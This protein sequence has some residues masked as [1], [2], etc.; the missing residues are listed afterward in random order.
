MRTQTT[1]KLLLAFALSV[2]CLSAQD[3]T[4]SGFTVTFEETRRWDNGDVLFHRFEMGKS[5][6]GNHWRLSKI[7]EAEKTY[8]GQWHVTE[9]WETTPE[10]D[11]RHVMAIGAGAKT[12]VY[13][14]NT[15][16]GS[17]RSAALHCV[18]GKAE[19]FVGYENSLGIKVA[20]V[21][22][23]RADG[24]KT[25]TQDFWEEQGCFPMTVR[26][27]S[28]GVETLSTVATALSFG[29]KEVVLGS[30]VEMPLKHAT[31]KMWTDLLGAEGAKNRIECSGLSAADT[32]DPVYE[33]LRKPAR[34]RVKN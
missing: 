6:T 1:S 12:T 8:P 2:A 10:G 3:V 27:S 14:D 34:L 30:L 29:G 33:Q 25:W 20:R 15:R 4:P 5:P 11:E 26:L 24:E 9:L 22:L 17:Q 21:I 31:A 32:A 28:S 23:T 13:D 19:K 18:A 16:P 7:A